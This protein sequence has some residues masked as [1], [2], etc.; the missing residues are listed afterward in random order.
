MI[1][2]ISSLSNRT[3]KFRFSSFHPDK[4]R[5]WAI[6]EFSPSGMKNGKNL[7]GL[8]SESSL[9]TSQFH[10]YIVITPR[11][12]SHKLQL[13]FLCYSSPFFVASFPCPQ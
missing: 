4:I 11:K 8:A 7:F 10:S 6:A 5:P 12:T 9:W 1:F 3:K 13:L 2:Q